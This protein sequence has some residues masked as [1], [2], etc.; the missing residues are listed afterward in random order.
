MPNFTT[1]Y[2]NYAKTKNVCGFCEQYAENDIATR[3]LLVR[4]LDRNNLREIIER[5]STES[6]DGLIPVLTEKAYNSSVTIEQLISYLDSKRQELIKQR[7]QELDG[8][9]DVLSEFP[10]VN[11]GV[12]NDKVDDIVKKFVR[13]KSLKTMDELEYELDNVMLPKIRQYSM[14]S[15]YNQTANDIIE[16]FFLQ[17]QKF[18]V[19]LR[20]LFFP[21]YDVRYLNLYR[22]MFFFF[23]RDLQTL[24]YNFRLFSVIFPSRF[25]FLLNFFPMF[26]HPF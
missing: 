1:L 4:S 12:R 10:V 20:T 2:T 23:R 24:P 5:Y 15:Y 25:L 11:C 3:F 13:N 21:V 7:T 9:Q 6:P 22:I 14:W 18:L 16:L 26:I 17:H 8:L 19:Q